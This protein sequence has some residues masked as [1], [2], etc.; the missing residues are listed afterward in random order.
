MFKIFFLCFFL[1]SCVSPKYGG[2]VIRYKA[3]VI[4]LDRAKDRLK[5]IE[6]QFKSHNIKFERF[7]AIDG[8]KILIT[9]LESGDTYSGLDLKN[10]LFEF[11]KTKKYYIDC[12]RE[13]EANFIYFLEGNFKFTAGELGVT[14]SHRSIIVKAMQ[15]KLDRIAIFEDDVKILSDDFAYL[16]SNVLI[17]MP[18]NSVVFLDAHGPGLARYKIDR[19]SKNLLI[20]LSNI[21]EV[22]GA[23]ALI[24][25]IK[26]AENL[27]REG[28]IERWPIDCKIPYLIK[29]KIGLGFLLNRKVATVFENMESEIKEMGRGFDALP[30]RN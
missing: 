19:N 2:E 1:T 4:N 24:F 10:H 25:D 27:L 29:Q 20:K 21:T 16:M 6:E 22:Y 13:K 3:F 28:D 17:H 14:C 30:N 11:S 18:K 5:I 15:E 9:D 7:S 26:F 23:Y 8:Y 12:G